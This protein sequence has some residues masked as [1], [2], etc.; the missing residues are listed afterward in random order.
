MKSDTSVRPIVRKATARALYLRIAAE[1]MT[2]RKRVPSI[3]LADAEIATCQMVS[4]KRP[5]GD[6]LRVGWTDFSN[7]RNSPLALFKG[8]RILVA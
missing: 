7:F 2:G 1:W 6:R 3:A 4:E 8:H 5:F